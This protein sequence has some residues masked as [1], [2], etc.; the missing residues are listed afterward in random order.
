MKW[1]LNEPK[2]G[3]IVRVKLGSIYHFGIYVSDD[4]VIQFGLPPVDLINR[5]S[6]KVVVLATP[7]EEFL[8]GYFLE[9]YEPDK[10]EKKKM[11]KPNKIVE[12]ARSR[13]GEGGYHILYNN[14]EHFVNQCAFGEKSSAQV[15]DLRAMWR[16]FPQVD[17]YVKS[18]PF[19][20]KSDKIYPVERK[21][22]IESCGS[23]RV[24]QEKYYA[25]KL[26]ES[27]VQK[28][29][30]KKLDKLKFSKIN[31]KWVCDGCEFSISH[32]DNLVAVV[33]SKTPVGIDV[34]NVD[35]ERFKKFPKDKILTKEEI[36]NNLSVDDNFLNSI[37]TAKEAIFKKQ[38]GKYFNPAKV[39]TLNQKYVTKK[40]I[41]DNKEY[42]LTIATDNTTFVKYYLD[43]DILLKK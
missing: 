26:L 43:D 20:V 35:L 4:E 33:V 29:F 41:S 23:G 5:D 2:E 30:N 15:D 1:T 32:T 34:E 31:S 39:N 38:A 42:Y 10:K 19:D 8:C 14:C 40:I 16:N 13:I 24:R 28:S 12:N 27:A 21:E 9:V 6:S 36:E 11:F 17:V 18:Y 7:I 3:D 22:E 37:W 25:W